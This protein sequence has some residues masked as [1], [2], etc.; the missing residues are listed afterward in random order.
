MTVSFWIILLAVL[1][2]G[3]LHSW[4]AS[5]GLKAWA[6][7]RFGDLAGRVYRLIYNLIAVVTLLPVLLL[8]VALLDKEIYRIP[9][10]WIFLTLFLQLVSVFTLLAGVLQTGL[11]KFLGVC[12]LVRCEG[13]E[14]PVLVVT[15]LYRWV[16]HPL[17][18]AGLVLVWL[19][20]WMS[21][22]LLALNIG[23]TLY[24]VA[25]AILEERKLLI[26]YGETYAQYRQRTPMLLPGLKFRS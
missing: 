13:E 10:P 24:I 11:S 14:K 7:S 4:L 22:N 1:V 18:S 19:M 15:G 25:G 16:R 12:Q 5:L 8:P 6:I 20:P 9:S 17:Y 3:V 21:W 26:E 23:I 2:Y